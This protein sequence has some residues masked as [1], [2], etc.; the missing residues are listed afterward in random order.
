MR[1]G[2]DFDNTII[3]YDEVFC[4]L[5]KS[6]GV[7]DST[8][9]GTKQSLRDHLHQSEEGD[10]IWQR[11]Q[12]QVYGRWIDQAKV[13][14]GFKEFMQKVSLDL[15]IQLFIVSHKTEYGHF[16]EAKINLRA[17]AK[18]WLKNQG[19]IPLIPEDHLF[20]ES[21][22]EEKIERIRSLNCTHFIDDLVEVFDDPHFPKEVKK[23]LFTPA[24][25]NWADIT[26]VLLSN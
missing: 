8:F 18:N 26:D 20:F 17:V 14:V 9:Q 12:G 6:L 13:F 21:S 24:V 11:L 3:C 25:Q 10:L 19:V 4:T 1:I 15:Q 16:D 22:R 7:I 5:A 23:I 2:I